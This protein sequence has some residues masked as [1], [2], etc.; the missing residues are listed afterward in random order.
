MQLDTDAAR[1]F[2]TAMVARADD[3]HHARCTHASAIDR[4]E[5]GLLGW[6]AV[7]PLE[8][9]IEATWE[10]ATFTTLLVDAVERD[11]RFDL[12]SRPALGE[13]VDLADGLAG[14]H[15]WLAGWHAVLGASGPLGEPGQLHDAELRSPYTILGSTPLALGRSLLLR[16]LSDTADDHQLRADEFGLVQMGPDHYVVV[17]PGATDLSSPDWNLSDENRTVRDLDRYAVR[18]SRS[19]DV[20]DNRYAGMVRDGLARVGVPDGAHLAIVGHSFGADTALDLAADESFTDRYDVSHV[21]AAGYWSQP[22]LADVRP[23]VEVLVLQNSIDGA[24]IAESVGHSQLAQ[25]AE[26]RG[27]AVG[28]LLDGDLGG[29]LG[30]TID[31]VGHELSAIVDAGE[32]VVEHADD[33]VETGGALATHRF[34]RVAAGAL[35]LIRLDAG[36]TRDGDIVVD[37][38]DGADRGAGHHPA[39]YASHVEGVADPEVVAFLDSL[40][41]AGY[42][43][44]GAAVAV[45]VSV[46]RD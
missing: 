13:L 15:G 8:T 26:A 4:L 6:H 29:A 40:G 46:P 41:G 24:V 10:L 12:G 19:S 21:V 16:A 35:D 1:R 17:L 3:L 44:W 36:V 9:A 43:G 33:L 14:R 27:S 28:H 32:F 2:A 31:A 38:F 25:A 23:G 5:L 37:V 30:S 11:D 22:Q 42:A 20:A 39:N 34:D 18:S 7:R 45:D